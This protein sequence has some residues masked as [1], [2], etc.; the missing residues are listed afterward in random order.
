MSHESNKKRIVLS[1]RCKIFYE[2]IE[3]LEI[4]EELRET[5]LERCQ[6][7]VKHNRQSRAARNVAFRRQIFTNSTLRSDHTSR[8]YSNVT[9][10]SDLSTDNNM[11]FNLRAS[12]DT[13]LSDD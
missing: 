11:I 13:N 1:F 12:S 10:D 4:S 6:F 5:T 2:P 9:D 3:L 7:M 8:S